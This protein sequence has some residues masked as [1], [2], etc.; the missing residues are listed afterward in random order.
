LSPAGV[1]QDV[2]TWVAELE[3]RIGG[4]EVTLQ[5]GAMFPGGDETRTANPLLMAAGIA[6]AAVIGMMF[7]KLRD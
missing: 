5:A 1:E 7:A 4:A 2:S 3:R 6:G